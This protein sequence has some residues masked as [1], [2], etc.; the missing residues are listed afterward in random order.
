MKLILKEYIESLLVAVVLALTLR[1]FVISTYKIPTSSMVPT[2][3]VG[4]FIFVYKLPYGVPIPFTGGERW[5]GM[6]P[7]R[8]DVVVFRYPGNENAN[9]VKRVVGLPGDRVAIKVGRLFIND[10]EAKYALP[11]SREIDDL[12]GHEY[13]SSTEETFDRSTH[14]VMMNA[15]D[16]AGSFGPVV[17]P[18]GHFFVLGDN[19]DSSDDSRYWGTVPLNNLEGR[20]VLVWMSFDWLNKWGNDRYPSIRWQRVFKKVR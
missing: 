15:V 8:G 6:L 2:L 19:R 13:Y 3:K 10:I 12:P 9:Y 1:V 16:K 20:V 18:P 5:G 17:I 4:D 14:F 11:S 7:N